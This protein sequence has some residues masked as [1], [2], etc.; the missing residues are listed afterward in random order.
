M[1]NIR[2]YKEKEIISS[3]E[4]M[5]TETKSYIEFGDEPKKYRR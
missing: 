2:V 4:D 5:I 1:E 3:T